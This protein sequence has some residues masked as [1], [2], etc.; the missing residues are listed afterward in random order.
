MSAVG[1]D[2]SPRKKHK[3]HVPISATRTDCDITKQR[4]EESRLLVA[5]LDATVQKD[6]VLNDFF[7]DKVVFSSQHLTVSQIKKVCANAQGDPRWN[8]GPTFC[9]R[10]NWDGLFSSLHTVRDFTTLTPDTI[11][12]NRDAFTLVFFTLADDDVTVAELRSQMMVQTT[13]LKNQEKKLELRLVQYTKMA[14]QPF[15]PVQKTQLCKIQQGARFYLNHLLI[16]VCTDMPAINALDV[17]RFMGDAPAVINVQHLKLPTLWEMKM[18]EVFSVFTTK[19]NRSMYM[20]R[21]PF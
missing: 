17:Y 15:I 10:K 3:S 2:E 19:A 1:E 7:E 9:L 20:Q 12:Q 11:S 5:V 14:N 8:I 16:K 21:T 6:V 18:P 13:W 4:A